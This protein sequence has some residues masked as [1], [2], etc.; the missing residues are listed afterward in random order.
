M[1][2][3]GLR[4]SGFG[5][6][7]A[8]NSW[9]KP[10]MKL[11][12]VPLALSVLLLTSSQAHA[13]TARARAK[14]GVARQAEAAPAGGNVQNGKRV[15]AAVGCANCHGSEGQGLPL[16]ARE[17][18]G[19]RIGPTR[20]AVTPF[21]RFVRNPPA[22]MPPFTDKAVSDSDLS[23]VHAYLQSLAPPLQS[24][25]AGNAQNGQRLFT[26]YGCYQC[27]GYEGQGST[28]TGASRIGP[29]QIP[30]SAFISYVRQPTGQMPPYAAKAVPEAEL[31]DIYA[32]L[33]SKPQ[34]ASA[35]NIPLLN[36]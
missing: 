4:F 30:V 10:I 28:Q 19:P 3:T 8:R 27:H 36:E 6:T 9:A 25:A 26:S 16:S 5:R 20:L 22:Q 23:D 14:A 34:P 13:I 35:H 18:A 24:S 29:P 32:Y 12:A 1:N 33:R 11:L 2:S 21:L 15:F 7:R 17:T 31:A